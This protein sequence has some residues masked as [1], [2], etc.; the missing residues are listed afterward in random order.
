MRQLRIKNGPRKGE[1]I[2]LG[3]ETVTLGRE[4]N[5][6]IQ[7][8]DQGVSRNHSEIFRIDEMYFIQDNLSKNGTFVN[9]AKID[10][11]LLKEGDIVLVGQTML[12]FESAS[13]KPKQ[14]SEEAAEDDILFSS[15]TADSPLST[16]VFRLEDMKKHSIDKSHGESETIKL[17]AFYQLAKIIS[18]HHSYSN[19][20]NKILSFIHEVLPCESVYIFIRDAETGKMKVEARSEKTPSGRPQ[21]SR[22][23][24]MQTLN[25]NQAVLTSDASKDVR[26]RATD[27]IQVR[28]VKSV[29]CVPLCD[30]GMI[31]GVLYLENSKE[32]RAFVEE[33]LE[34]TTAMG[35]LIGMVL[36]DFRIRHFERERLV[37]AIKT[38]I[39]ASE[40]RSPE[41]KGHSERV[42]R[43]ANAISFQMK[44]S[45]GAVHSIEYAALLHDVGKI[46][47]TEGINSQ[48]EYPILS[49]QAARNIKGIEDA[50][51][52]I[53]SHAERIDGSGFPDKLDGDHIPLGAKIVGVADYFDYLLYHGS[54]DGSP[55]S[56]SQALTK[57]GEASGKEFDADVVT[58]LI[59]AYREGA[60]AFEQ[61]ELFS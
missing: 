37:S 27:S 36:Q 5:C 28:L 2:Q 58:A 60:L 49:E 40:Q 34:L 45:H 16:V 52:A 12:V 3:N 44:L 35:T 31:T 55:L 21:V 59:N 11:Y 7:I 56:A 57:L 43:Y 4:P 51:P 54:D 30:L 15:E 26:F 48:D 61:V 47:I 1:I 9:D 23:I 29:I 46:L 50:L 25:N 38:L 24:I 13:D 14:K 19:L 33:D 22:S 10:K 8:R 17:H 6:T 32:S 41:S 20:K 42:A 39:A 53:R 18:Q